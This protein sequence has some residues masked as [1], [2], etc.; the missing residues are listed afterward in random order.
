MN[1]QDIELIVPLLSDQIEFTKFSSHEFVLSNTTTKHYLKI[2]DSTFNLL[3][4]IDGNRNI[5]EIC[6]HYSQTYKKRIAPRDLHSLLYDK[7]VEYGV[8]QGFD[9]RI[10][11]YEKPGYLKLS[12][13][14]IP[15]K[16]VKKIAGIFHFMF[17]KW[18]FLIAFPISI[19]IL[20]YLL[21][22]N[23]RLYQ[24]TNIHDFILVYLITMTAS[25]FFH[26]IG[27]ATAVSFFG[28]KIGSIGGGFY[29]FSPV[30]FADVSDIWRLAQNQRIIVNLSGM[31]FEVML[32]TIIS[33][34]GFIIGNTVLMMI[35]L[36]VCSQTFFNLL[37]F[38]RAD[39]YWVLSDSIK[40][41]NL[42]KHGYG[43]V[44]DLIKAIFR[45]KKLDWNKTDLIIFLFGV[46]NLS[47]VG[48]FFY[49][50][51]IKNPNS[52]LFFP[53]NSMQFIK[54]LF[55]P[56]AKTSFEQL[57]ELVIPIIFIYLVIKLVARVWKNNR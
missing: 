11:R 2:S 18:F 12:F 42:V 50:V 37:P 23:F 53:K 25:G 35:A 30:L 5:S 52:L 41:P 26:E 44:K 7:L 3:S 57:G 20:S 54:D 45:S 48:I 10:K 6:D 29:I 36:I 16:A 55:N 34:V 38:L 22:T 32:C 1:K 4:I 28:S 46:F 40:T 49:Y 33:L 19:I 39:G 51:L 24:L 47:F 56:E 21:I 14:I 8:L 17:K 43:R 15:E 9:E 27:H 13:T 31:Y